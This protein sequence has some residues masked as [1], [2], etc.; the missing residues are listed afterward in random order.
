[1]TT[2]DNF[3]ELTDFRD[4][5]E[6]KYLVEYILADDFGFSHR[7]SPFLMPKGTVFEHNYGTY[8]VISIDRKIKHIVLHC[9]RLENKT[10]KFDVLFNM[11]NQFN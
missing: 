8:E 3:D 9:V 4:G 10:P 1:M 5:E 7:C 11:V 2:I 6:D